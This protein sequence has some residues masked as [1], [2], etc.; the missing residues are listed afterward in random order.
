MP[1]QPDICL[2]VNFGHIGIKFDGGSIVSILVQH[3]FYD[4][5]EIA[6]ICRLVA[7]AHLPPKIRAS[8][9]A[10]TA[11]IEVII[12]LIVRGGAGAIKDGRRCPL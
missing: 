5:G 6:G 12:D 11:E 1:C 7:V 4:T 9:S 3:C 10:T 8:L 2:G